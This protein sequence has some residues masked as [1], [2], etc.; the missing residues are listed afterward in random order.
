MKK[1]YLQHLIAFV[2]CIASAWQL[3]AQ[4]QIVNLGFE[5]WDAL[6]TSSE[7]PVG[8]NS[9]MNAQNN[10][11]SGFVFDLARTQKVERNTDKRPGSAG[12]YSAR[13]WSN[14]VFGVVANGNLTTGRIMIGSTTADSPDNH[15]R[16]LTSNS[17]YNQPFT[18]LPDSLV[19][20]VKY[21]AAAGNT[22]RISA[23][24]HGNYDYR[25]P[26]ASDPNAA[27]F[28][29]GRAV[30]NYP[31]TGGNWIRLSIPFDYNFPHSDPRYIL[32]TF[33]TNSTPG[34]GAS[35]DQ[36]FIDDLEFIYVPRVTV[37]PNTAQ[38]LI[39]NQNGATLTVSENFT[40]VSREWKFSTVSGS[41]YTSFATPQTGSTLVPGFATPNTYFVVCESNHNGTIVRSNE[42]I[43]NVS[44]FTATITPDN[45]QTLF[46]NE[47][48]NTLTVSESP[49][50]DSRV[51]KFATTS[52]G[53][54]QAFSPSITGTGLTPLFSDVNTYYIV[55]ES[56]RSGVTIV[57]NEVEIDVLQAIVPSISITPS[58]SQFIEIN[59]N[60][61][62]LTANE[63]VA[64]AGREWKFATSAS[65]PFESF[66]PAETGISY[67]PQFAN[68]GIYLVRCESEM[69]DTIRFSNVVTIEAA[70]LEISIA[71]AASQ[72][73]YEN[74]AG[75]LLTVSENRQ[76][77]TREW[78]F[79]TVSG[80]PY[81]S[82]SP[83][84]TNTTYLP[85]FTSTGSY[86]I[87]CESTFSGIVK[88]SNE[89]E[90]TVNDGPQLIATPDEDQQLFTNQQGNTITAEAAGFTVVNPEWKF[91][92]SINSFFQSF[93]T[94]ITELT[95]TPQFIFAGEYFV[96]CEAEILGQ[97]FASNV[98]KIIVNEQSTSIHLIAEPDFNVYAADKFIHVDLSGI[99][100]TNARMVVANVKGQL[101][102]EQQLSS[103][104]MNK[105]PVNASEG[106]YFFMIESKDK[107]YQGK[108][109]M[110]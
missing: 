62:T 60:G 110:R 48:G 70:D 108:L 26:E 73:T 7:E 72:I 79:A 12:N 49:A 4:T 101:V 56:T 36:V 8:W 10:G 6:G 80:G 58:S 67:T 32:I 64:S 109:Y 102:A 44:N 29:V 5:D 25:D 11:V 63:T 88:Q 54:Y 66:T 50:A 42:V 71:P 27:N 31:P 43:I 33:T 99:E 57:S 20:W 21:S 100:L 106:I 104:S 105:F 17:L 38:N 2:F 76:P 89:V 53:P 45:P 90:I 24:I 96:R 84:Q 95:Y 30:L 81:Q 82:F 1:T 86:F 69:N 22:A 9:F 65:G 40:P 37:A 14:S 18:G 3:Q 103:N 55:C 52:G 68:E 35:G 41:G 85:L 75:D 107:L 46:Q 59:Q 93:S 74:I 28:V 16:T 98:V 15:N 51:W 34:G 77:D 78:K 83:S 97:S 47:A 94:P 61:T 23:T 92:N 19:V 87:V 39:I 91:A 13:I